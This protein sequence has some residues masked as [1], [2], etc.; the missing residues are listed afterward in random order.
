MFREITTSEIKNNVFEMIDKEWFLL[1]AGDR[2]EMNTMTC[3]W[4]TVGE[5]WNRRVA[6]AYVR[7]TRHT[8]NFTEKGGFFTLSFFGKNHRDALGICG[9][10][11]GR[12]IDKVAAT[13]LTPV[14]AEDAGN[15][16]YFEE[17]ETVF[18]CRK[19]YSDFID[20]ENFC[21]DTL[22]SQIYGLKDYHKFYVGEILHVYVKE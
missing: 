1:T 10:K 7:K 21:D 17:A 4:G 6:I 16:P 2:S 15:V 20:A 19:L 8:F 5:L 22:D 14:Y 3:S 12:D 13:G 11:S 9:S 18:V